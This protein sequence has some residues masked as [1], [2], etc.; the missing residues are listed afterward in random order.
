MQ[1][2]NLIN[3]QFETKKAWVEISYKGKKSGEIL[4]EAKLLSDKEEKENENE[5]EEYSNI[6]DSMIDEPDFA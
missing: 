5:H 6:E 1:I 2:Q 3:N 4:L